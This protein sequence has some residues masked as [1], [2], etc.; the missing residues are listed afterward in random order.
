MFLRFFLAVIN[1]MEGVFAADH[2][3][4]NINR[5]RHTF[6][7]SATG[8]A[9]TMPT[10]PIRVEI[11]VEI[12]RGPVIQGCFTYFDLIPAGAFNIPWLKIDLPVKFDTCAGR[13][14]SISF[15]PGHLSA[16]S[17]GTTGVRRGI[18]RCRSAIRSPFDTGRVAVRAARKH[19]APEGTGRTECRQGSG[20]HLNSRRLQYVPCAAAAGP[21]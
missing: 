16:R 17:P 8:Q 19:P 10:R 15:R 12:S 3:S 2:V 14:V 4:N 9:R 11:V 20:N 18:G 13:K 5:F 7:L 1:L 6:I 21:P